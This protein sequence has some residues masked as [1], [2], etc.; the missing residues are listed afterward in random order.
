MKSNEFVFRERFYRDIQAIEAAPSRLAA[1][2]LLC[3]FGVTRENRIKRYPIAPEV[4]EAL[5][6]VLEPMF[7]CVEAPKQKR[8]PNTFL[9]RENFYEAFQVIEDSNTRLACYELLCEFGISGV[10]GIE[11]YPI[12]SEKKAAL[13]LIL[14]HI[15]NSVEATKLRYERAVANGRKG[16]LKGGKLGGRGHKKQAGTTGQAVQPEVTVKGGV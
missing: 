13:A 8:E 14:G 16:G 9:F 3:C 4:Q 15:F 5:A 6:P 12:E 2:D 1:Y 10:N 7:T 11:S